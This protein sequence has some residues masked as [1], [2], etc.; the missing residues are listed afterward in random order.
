MTDSRQ[1]PSLIILCNHVA[2]N[3]IQLAVNIPTSWGS[4]YLCEC[5]GVL[6]PFPL[7]WARFLEKGSKNLIYNC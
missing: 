1:V 7:V 2:R 4:D 6:R 5:V 3:D